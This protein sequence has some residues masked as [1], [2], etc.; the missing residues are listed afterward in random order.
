MWLPKPAS[1]SERRLLSGDGD[2]ARLSLGSDAR[3]SSSGRVAFCFPSQ[4]L[5]G[6]SPQRSLWPRLGVAS[7]KFDAFVVTATTHFETAHNGGD[8][9]ALVQPASM[10]RGLRGVG[11]AA[12]FVRSSPYN[13]SRFRLRTRHMSEK[14]S[15]G[16][17][18]HRI[19]SYF[20][21]IQTCSQLVLR[22]EGARGYAYAAHAVMRLD[23]LDGAEP[24]PGVAH[25]ARHGPSASARPPC[26]PS[27]RHRS[28]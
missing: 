15:K 25:G 23:L 10:C 4:F 14:S 28:P 24:H 21:T 27:G 17:I 1:A 16:L 22:E 11:F 19:A 9:G 6:A 12:C 18:P 5:R 3:G 20:W 13:A 7:R 2:D 8:C 26:P